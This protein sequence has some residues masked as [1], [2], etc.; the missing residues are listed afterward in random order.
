MRIQDLLEDQFETDR[1]EQK[2]NGTL[3]PVYNMRNHELNRGSQAAVKSDKK[4]P[5]MVKKYNIRTYHDDDKPHRDSPNRKD[6]GFN[7]FINYLIDHKLMGVNPHFPRV[8]DIKTI[9]DK[10]GHR[11]YT[12]TV[13]KLLESTVISKEEMQAFIEND[14]HPDTIYIDPD[15]AQYGREKEWIEEA[16]HRI[17]KRLNLCITQMSTA[18][19]SIKS[20]TLIECIKILHKLDKEFPNQLDVH[21]NNLMWRRTQHGLVLVFNDPIF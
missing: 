7:Q 16:W 20:E 8:Y 11:I 1:G 21:M 18:R 14:L 19:E 3:K 2:F 10:T 13:E 17:T 5:H 9:T 6:D 4:D 12:Y 15:I